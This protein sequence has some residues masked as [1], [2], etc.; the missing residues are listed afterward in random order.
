[1]TASTPADART[2]FEETLEMEMS[3]PS[4]ISDAALAYNNEPKPDT[5]FTYAF[6]LS[7]SRRD[8]E[9]AY[10]V[11]LFDQLISDKYPHP[12]DCYYGKS[13]AFYLNKDYE[14]ARAGV[15]D[16]L[17][18][19]PG[20]QKARALHLATIAVMEEREKKMNL[21][22]GSGVLAVGIGAVVGL[23]GIILSKKK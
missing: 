7:R 6:A 12:V 18:S 10:A 17:R 21:A 3:P 22:V 14:S 2:L 13:V 20:H 23:A 5:T 1:M 16:I 8:S 15:E 11:V 4:L 19:N 9:R